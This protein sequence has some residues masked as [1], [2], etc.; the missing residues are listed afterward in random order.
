MPT[1]LDK[2]ILLPSRTSFLYDSSTACTTTF[3]AIYTAHHTND[4]KAHGLAIP[5]ARVLLAFPFSRCVPFLL[6]RAT[7]NSE[8]LENMAQN[9][10]KR[11][12]KSPTFTG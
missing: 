3:A 7:L 1:G 9:E 2:M 12:F 10:L 11:G 4:V 8:E 5:Y 6:G